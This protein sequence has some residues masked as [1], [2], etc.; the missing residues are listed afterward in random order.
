M[1]SEARSHTAQ[2]KRAIL[3]GA[4]MIGACGAASA[5]MSGGVLKVGIISDFSS[6]YA[7]TGGV[8]NE[9][10]YKMAIEDFGGMMGGKPIE[11]IK[12]DYQNKADVALTIAR[13]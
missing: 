11:F 12:A 4:A 13:K 2:F 7:D 10:T 1:S 6:V 9:I 5:D 3:A 8:G